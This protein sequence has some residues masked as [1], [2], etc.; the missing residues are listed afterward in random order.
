MMGF[1]LSPAFQLSLDPHCLQVSTLS[2]T[3]QH[4]ALSRTQPL[5]P[6]QLLCHQTAPCAQHLGSS[7]L[8][9]SPFPT[10]THLYILALQLQPVKT[11]SSFQSP[12]I[13]P[14]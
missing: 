12:G 7:P 6:L 9:I 8:P 13:S 1:W 5:L 2:S 3:T 4:P 14:P 10:V 11:L